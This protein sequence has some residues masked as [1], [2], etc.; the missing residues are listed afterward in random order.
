M[1]T[2]ETNMRNVQYA[3]VGLDAIGGAFGRSRQTARR[4]INETSFP[5]CRLPSGAWCTTP[6]LIDR[7]VIERK[8]IANTDGEALLQELE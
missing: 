8:G 1:N 5:A 7:W 4:W 3:F 6:A 2:E